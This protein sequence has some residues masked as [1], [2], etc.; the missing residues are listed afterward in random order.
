[1]SIYLHKLDLELQE[2]K[3]SGHRE[4]ERLETLDASLAANI[5]Q[6][7]LK[8]IQGEISDLEEMR[9]SHEAKERRRWCINMQYKLQEGLVRL[10]SMLNEYAK[11]VKLAL[12]T[13][14]HEEA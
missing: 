3:K 14:M 13:K 11:A 10:Y 1:M 9:E 12:T 8:N 4:D 2:F 6:S 5:I 7:R